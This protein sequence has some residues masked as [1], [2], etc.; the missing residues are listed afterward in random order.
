MECNYDLN[1]NIIFNGWTN[2]RF[3]I[4]HFN[5]TSNNESHSSFNYYHSNEA[6]NI[7]HFNM[8]NYH[9]SHLNQ[10]NLS[11]NPE[12]LN[13]STDDAASFKSDNS[14]AKLVNNWSEC[15]VLQN[16]SENLKKEER[17]RSACNRERVRMKVRAYENHV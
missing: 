16:K 10:M 2:E 17:R 4:H 3:D 6:I 1:N 9:N 7:Q 14:N 15:D 5:D 12:L 8:D 13:S 11:I